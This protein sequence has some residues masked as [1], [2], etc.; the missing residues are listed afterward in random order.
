MEDDKKV[1]ENETGIEK[2]PVY[3]KVA[4]IKDFTLT[5]ISSFQISPHSTEIITFHKKHPLRELYKS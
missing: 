2:Q 5:C 4:G 3:N 1:M